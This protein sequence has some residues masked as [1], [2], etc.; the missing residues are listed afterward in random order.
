MPGNIPTAHPSG[1]AAG[2]APETMLHDI[3]PRAGALTWL[4]PAAA[5]T[6]LGRGARRRWRWQG[7]EKRSSPTENT[8]CG[9]MDYAISGTFV[10]LGFLFFEKAAGGATAWILPQ[11]LFLV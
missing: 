6:A 4:I 2:G 8:P 10:P 7:A 3:P 5:K 1:G 9:T 11:L